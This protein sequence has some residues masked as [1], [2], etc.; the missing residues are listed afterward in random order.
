MAY[1]NYNI[2]SSYHKNDIGKT[3]YNTV[4]TM[5]PSI[6]IEFGTLHGYS[7]VAMAQALRDLG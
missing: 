2:P 7:A 4:L 1:F 6:I 3:L 5:N